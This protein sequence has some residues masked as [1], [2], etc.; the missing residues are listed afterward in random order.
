MG[1]HPWNVFT[2][3]EWFWLA[4]WARNSKIT[5][6]VLNSWPFFDQSFRLIW[7]WILG[8]G[9]VEIVFDP[10]CLGK[11]DSNVWLAVIFVFWNGLAI[12]KKATKNYRIRVCFP[13]ARKMFVSCFFPWIYSLPR[14][15]SWQKKVSKDCLFKM[16]HIILVVTWL[17]PGWR[18]DSKKLIPTRYLEKPRIFVQGMKAT[19]RGTE[20]IE[21]LLDLKCHQGLAFWSFTYTSTMKTETNKV[22]VCK[23]SKGTN[24][25]KKTMRFFIFHLHFTTLRWHSHLPVPFWNRLPN[26]P[27]WPKAFCEPGNLEFCPPV[28]WVQA[29]KPIVIQW[30]YKMRDPR[31]NGAENT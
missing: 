4:N 11:N 29:E 30:R 8:G 27:N 3:L 12:P 1:N 10:E 2:E 22:N 28:S 13:L 6:G 14:M 18:V 16:F 17:Q 23:C 9:V 19:E 20:I 21:N 24:P 25:Q 15:Q 5:I 26:S 31:I 7:D